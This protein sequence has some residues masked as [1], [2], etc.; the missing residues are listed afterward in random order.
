MNRI[1]EK[2][3]TYLFSRS[4]GKGGQNVNK[5]STRVQLFWSIGQSATFSPEDKSWLFFVLKNQ[6]S[7]D[8]KLIITSSAERTQ[9]ANLF[10]ARH[11]LEQIVQKALK[12]P[13]IRHKTRPT[14]SSR[15]QRL[16]NKRL[17]SVKKQQRKLYD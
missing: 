4:G 8:G 5:T 6:L 15:L 14:H 7:K 2:E 3:I 10:S 1:P 16:E 13:K 9:K 11:K 17:I 12:K